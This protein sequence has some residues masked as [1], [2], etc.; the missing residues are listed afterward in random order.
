MNG[1]GAAGEA[2]GADCDARGEGGR[3][4]G[5]LGLW[6][7]GIRCAVRGRGSAGVMVVGWMLCPRPVRAGGI[8]SMHHM[9]LARVQEARKPKGLR[10]DAAGRRLSRGG[11]KNQTEAAGLV[12][13]RKAP[14]CRD[15]SRGQT[16]RVHQSGRG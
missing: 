2:A 13:A 16:C 3:S 9:E 5:W 8:H 15:L 4:G 1:R 12:E 14:T 11:S 7:V 10:A 6:C